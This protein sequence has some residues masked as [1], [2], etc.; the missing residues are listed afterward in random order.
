[1][2]RYSTSQVIEELQIKTTMQYHYILRRTNIQNTDNSKLQGG[3]GQQEVSFIAGGNVK[4]DRYCRRQFGNVLQNQ[5]YS[6]RM[7][8][9][10]SSLI[11]AQMDRKLCPHKNLHMD[12]YSS[13]ILKCPNL[14]TAKTAF[15]R[16]MD[17]KLVHPDYG[18]LF[19]AKIQ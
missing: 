2:K 18:I 7:I 9:Q 16:R 17:R 19:S 11:F 10:P 8:Q 12:L 13:F 5:T 1:M 14:E 4:W 15:R 6:Y 3:C